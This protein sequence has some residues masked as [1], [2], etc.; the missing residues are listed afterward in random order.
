MP[1]E[2]RDE[3]E[4]L[5]D[6]SSAIAAEKAIAQRNEIATERAEAG[7]LLSRILGIFATWSLALSIYGSKLPLVGQEA[8]GL[9][10]WF[11]LFGVGGAVSLFTW[12]LT[13]RRPLDAQRF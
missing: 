13:R 3:T 12:H 4:A 6:L 7:Q 10:K 5:A 8:P 11:C 2:L 9:F 1:T